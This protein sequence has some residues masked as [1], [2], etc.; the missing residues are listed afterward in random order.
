LG[1]VLK[2]LIV[3]P[4]DLSLELSS[5]V[6]WRP[7]IERTH[8]ADG[9]DAVAVAAELRPNLVVLDGADLEGAL[10]LVRALRADPR[11]RPTAIAVLTRGLPT[12]GED[13]LLGAGANAVLPNPVDPFVWDPRLEELLSVPRR[14]Y[15]RIPVR[16]R[17]WSGLVRETEEIGGEVVNIGARGVLLES[18]AALELGAKLGL[19]FRLPGDSTDVH[20]VG[21]VV[22]PAGGGDGLWRT[23][24]EFL[25]Y[26]GDAR[27][28][29]VAFVESEASPDR[30][31]APASAVALRL[32]SFEQ[33][34]EWEEELRGSEL[35][36][37]I[38]LDSAIDC[39]ITVDQDGRVIEFNASARRLFG[40]TR[41]EVFGRDVVDRI[42]RPE[43]R[44]GLRRLL[45]EFVETGD[46]EHLGRRCEA[47]AMRADGST[48]PVE[49]EVFPAWIKGK[50]LL[51]AFLRDLTERKRAR[52]VSALRH[53]CTRVLA[54]AAS[55]TEALPHLCRLVVQEL[56]VSA[57]RLWLLEEG[58]T[59]L[60]VA[61]MWP[62]EA[63]PSAAAPVATGMPSSV[64]RSGLSLRVPMRAAS[65]SVGYVE[66]TTATSKP[67]D[68]EWLEALQELASQIGL[69][70]E[71][72]WA[73]EA[74]RQG[75]AGM[76]A[77]ADAIPG[78]LYQYEVRPDGKES[79][80][81][82][83]RGAVE[84][85]G[86]D[87][88]RL[89][90]EGSVP[91]RLVI[92]EHEEG[93]RQSIAT[94]AASLSPWE[95]TFQ[96]TTDTGLKW[97]HGQ[98]VPSRLPNGGIAWNGI[99]VDV[100][101]QKAAQEALLRVN[102]D[103]DRR[104]ADLRQAEAELQR[105]A[106]YD[107]LT[108]LPNRSFFMESLD[109][110]LLRA[111]RRKDRVALVFIDVDGFKAVND[112][113]GHAAG[114]VLLRSL[115]ERLRASTRKSDTVARIGGDEF[116]VMVQDLGR[117]D[118]AAVVAQGLLDQLSRPCLLGDREVTVTASVGISVFPEDGTD[119][120]TLLKNADLAM[121]RAKQEGKNAFRFFT[122]SMSE[123]ARERMLLQSSLRR[124]VE[125]GEF[126]MHYQP[127]VHGGGAPSLEALIRWR[128][129]EKGL[130]PPADFI[131]AAEEGGHILTIGAWVLRTATAFAQGLARADVRVAV[132]LS[133]RQF[134]DPDLVT[135]VEGAL[136]A[137]GLAPGRLE[138][139]VTESALMSD[140][141]EVSQRLEHLRSIGLE[142]TLDDFGSGYS[143][144]GYLK[145]FK[146]HR[147]KIDR[148]FV[149]DLPADADSAAIV[150]AILAMAKSLGLDV[151]AE[152]VEN[153]EQLRFL[154]ERGCRSFQ[155]YYFSRP[156]PGAEVAGYLAR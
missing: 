62:L 60:G 148:T 104:L 67:L 74:L 35:R 7:D 12:E 116:T 137:S 119:G 33:A 133:A 140:A 9:S 47:Q 91:W 44:E 64:E 93:L 56:G 36:K 110:T 147:I 37:T 20:V 151:V 145:R 34:R 135:I 109:Q 14:R 43:D 130:V 138:L 97:I 18:P 131:P 98:S 111:E 88:V 113:Y 103:L 121:Y 78:A 68:P 29:I 117:A 86:V 10:A 71:R 54:D 72:H 55:P 22:R 155:G 118:D 48:F 84:L 63:A 38:I 19:T 108:G 15:H 150:D 85:F 59:R 153:A 28:R 102:D 106:R 81:F 3:G 4:D 120:G 152:G 142:I 6:L 92:P 61:A 143:S 139:E 13:L 73:E 114:D 90:E 101:A 65:R 79:F 149:R 134:L 27:D 129:P 87:S 95:A 50:V 128:H 112:S 51:T 57:T 80:T 26:R 49:V 32:R 77:V 5:T 126:E 75:Q 17:D 107:S 46:A 24:V 23:G 45:R 100:S 125:T 94:S 132:N 41:A 42:V 52:R 124:A 39:I 30:P 11:A 82:M 96:V 31:G 70:V 16:L 136:A 40:H 123:R 105:L 122:A 115:A 141:E 66:V 127:V 156:L 83:S 76:A 144:L 8:A 21:Q 58:G 1:A 89:R 146:F 154:E 2:L 69:F 99:F 25:V 53:G